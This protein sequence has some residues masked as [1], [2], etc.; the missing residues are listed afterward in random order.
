MKKCLLLV[1][2]LA[3][4]L[5][6]CSTTSAKS[7]K[8]SEKIRALIQIEG[9][10]EV[11]IRAFADKYEDP[12]LYELDCGIID[13]YKGD[14]ENAVES[15]EY[16]D[17]EMDKRVVKSSLEGLK[18]YLTND[19]ARAYA[20]E[21][22]EVIFSNIFSALSYVQMGNLEE[23]LV[24]VKQSD[25][26]L[27]NYQH[28]SSDEESTL[29]KVV[30]NLTPNPFIWLTD[31]YE[32]KPYTQSATA[33][34]LSM[35]TYRSLNDEGNAEVD[36]RR[37]QEKGFYVDPDDTS[38][39]KGKARVNVVSLNGLI[40]RK[41]SHSAYSEHL[42]GLIDN[43]PVLVPYT[44]SWPYV[45]NGICSVVST[46]V[47]VSNGESFDLVPLENVTKSAR[48]CV[49]SSLKKTYL[50]SWYRG[51]NKI[52][53]LSALRDAAIATAR[54]SDNEFARASAILGAN[55]SFWIG[56]AAVNRAEVAD[57]RMAMYLP[58]NISVGGI[59]LEP[60]VYDFNVTYRLKNG[61]TYSIPYYNVE[62]KEN[63]LNLLS[64]HCLK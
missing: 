50:R 1:S 7:E 13:F 39:P 32:G 19:Y 31:S 17:Q 48:L 3:L 43:Y 20:G 25:I 61:S 52:L 14:Y 64:P 16:A 24:D 49:N 35:I 10:E 12:V 26:K 30:F 4:L 56:V 18:S 63:T 58:D 22:Y 55:A 46:R 57:T 54:K 8:T 36:M 42:F 2:L 45:E 59:T 44:V 33:D 51:Y 38:V 21:A 6:S 11:D 41:V 62:V 5:V 27:I 9:V 15:L 40:G 37:L 34:Y 47:S 28:I 60:G 29:T 23:A 53:A